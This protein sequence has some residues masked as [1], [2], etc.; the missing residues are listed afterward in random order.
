MK[1]SIRFLNGLFLHERIT[2][3]WH[4]VGQKCKRLEF[5][6]CFIISK[7]FIIDDDKIKEYIILLGIYSCETYFSNFPKNH[8]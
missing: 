5:N 2:E 1:F 3:N 8:K 4:L 7:I 6:D